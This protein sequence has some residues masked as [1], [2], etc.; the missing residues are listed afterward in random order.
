MM[1]NVNHE[2]MILAE[3]LRTRVNLNGMRECL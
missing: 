2:D 3:A 1:S